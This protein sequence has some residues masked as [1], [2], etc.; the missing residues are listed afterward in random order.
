MN[1]NFFN[2]PFH[3]ACQDGDL[4]RV[5][6]LINHPFINVAHKHNFAIRYACSNGHIKIVKMLLNISKVNP[7]DVNNFAIRYASLNGHVEIVKLLL[8]DP[9]VDPSADNNNALFNA[10]R[11]E[12]RVIHSSLLY[13][14][15]HD[16]SYFDIVQLLLKDSRVFNLVMHDINI[17]EHSPSIY[18]HVSK[19]L[20][21]SKQE[22]K[23]FL[24][25]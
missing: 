8:K 10:L 1:L 13:N 18:G 14:T 22:A 11:Q 19:L 5:K 6:S 3:I 9:R 2:P 20:N 12:Q 24:K 15:L 25:F 16:S 17:H 4:K 23:L 21:I 7:S